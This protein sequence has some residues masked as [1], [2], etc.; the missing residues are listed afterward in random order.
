MSEESN[1]NT[2]DLL[3]LGE[4]G[5]QH[6]FGGDFAEPSV[7]APPTASGDDFIVVNGE[8]GVSGSSDEVNKMVYD[9]ANN[10]Q[11]TLKN[12][13]FAEADSSSS[14]VQRKPTPAVPEPAPQTK[15]D[16]KGK[17]EQSSTS[18]TVCPYYLLSM[19]SI[20]LASSRPHFSSLKPTLYSK[21]FKSNRLRL[22]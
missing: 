12:K 14:T 4:H 21:S 19:L 17:K 7:P 13:V 16:A 9:M 6:H 11:E 20:Y 1:F 15:P 5:Q 22:H 10:V 2:Q 3:D 18:C 8:K